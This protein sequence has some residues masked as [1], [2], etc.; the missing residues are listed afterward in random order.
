MKTEMKRYGFLAVTLAIAFSFAFSTMTL[1]N[2][3]DSPKIEL[4]FIGNIQEQPVFQLDVKN[5][6]PDEFTITIRD[7]DGTVLYFDR[8]TA[9]KIS[10]KF[11]LN[12]EEIGNNVLQLEVRSRNTGKGEV[13]EINRNTR[14]VEET[15]VSRI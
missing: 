11:Q 10:R 6:T 8:L 9:R 13:Y 7:E 2:R 15:L 1:A 14:I 5:A 12:T 3:V 4:K